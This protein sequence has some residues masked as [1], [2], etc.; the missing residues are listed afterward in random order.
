MKTTSDKLGFCV[1]GY[2]IKDEKGN[3]ADAGYKVHTLITDKDVVPTI[4]KIM[5]DD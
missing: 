4:R 2:L 3:K 1:C 5:L